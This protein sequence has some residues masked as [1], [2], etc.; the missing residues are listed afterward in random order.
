ML[1]LYLSFFDIALTSQQ[2][3][4]KIP[5]NRKLGN[6]GPIQNEKFTIEKKI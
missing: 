1:K 2:N 3:R 5:I 6:T 4:C